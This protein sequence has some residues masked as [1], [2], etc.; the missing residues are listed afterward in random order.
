MDFFTLDTK[1]ER[2]KTPFVAPCMGAETPRQLAADKQT[3]AAILNVRTYGMNV[4][5]NVQP[6]MGMTPNHT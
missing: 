5:Y 1:A 2:V 6:F 3:T 4:R